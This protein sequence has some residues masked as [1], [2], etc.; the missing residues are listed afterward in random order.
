MLSDQYCPCYI[1]HSALENGA[2]RYKQFYPHMACFD[3]RGC[4]QMWSMT[5]T[6]WIRRTSV[7]LW[8]HSLISGDSAECHRRH[9]RCRRQAAISFFII[10]NL[11]CPNSVSVKHSCNSDSIIRYKDNAN[12]SSTSSLKVCP[13]ASSNSTA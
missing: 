2:P 9:R 8:L 12:T 10:F 5:C 13:I 11:N 1:P 6:Q 4:V 3:M 7:Q